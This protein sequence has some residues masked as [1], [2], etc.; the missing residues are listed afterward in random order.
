MKNTKKHPIFLFIALIFT[1]LTPYTNAQQN[2]ASI[3]LKKLGIVLE[4][5][6]PTVP[7]FSPEANPGL[8]GEQEELRKRCVEVLKYWEIAPDAFWYDRY[9]NFRQI[10]CNLNSQLTYSHS[11][12]RSYL[13]PFQDQYPWRLEKLKECERMRE[14]IEREAVALFP[15]VTAFLDKVLQNEQLTPLENEKFYSVCSGLFS[16][17]REHLSSEE[18]VAN[19]M[20][21]EEIAKK[22]DAKNANVSDYTPGC[23]I[24]WDSDRRS[25]A[26]EMRFAVSQKRTPK[27]APC[28]DFAYD[29]VV[30]QEP[31]KRAFIRIRNL[32]NREA[33]SAVIPEQIDFPPVEGIA[34]SAFQRCTNQQKLTVPSPIVE[35][36]AERCPNTEIYT[37]HG[38]YV[39]E[40]EDDEYEYEDETAETAEVKEVAKPVE[41]APKPQEV[42]V[43]L[44][45]KTRVKIPMFDI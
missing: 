34:D 11:K 4:F 22:I 19:F 1:F 37:E 26:Q 42:G 45:K 32:K 12:T 18:F 13:I 7:D 30:V 33:T 25:Y 43:V 21:L 17:S 24:G 29:T 40:Y 23:W 31:T 15:Q 44:N 6:P 16:I 2:R 5:P 3:V 28:L 39:R 10:H 8:E 27:V 14:S 35:I 38:L 41:I 20:L 9:D 36:A